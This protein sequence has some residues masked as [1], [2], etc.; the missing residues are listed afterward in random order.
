MITIKSPTQKKD[1]LRLFYIF[2]DLKKEIDVNLND[3]TLNK[4]HVTFIPKPIHL[5]AGI[6]V[7]SVFR[8]DNNIVESVIGSL[9]FVRHMRNL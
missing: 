1:Q 3:Q 9:L 2:Y 7:Y 4:V 8:E 5:W 6:K